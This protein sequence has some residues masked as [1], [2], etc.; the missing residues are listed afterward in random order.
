M[1]VCLLA[2]LEN[3]MGE[4]HQFLV[5]CVTQL[6][7]NVAGRYMEGEA[8]QKSYRVLWNVTE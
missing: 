2:Q 8:L 4:L 5:V 1:S 6:L 7:R 3:Y